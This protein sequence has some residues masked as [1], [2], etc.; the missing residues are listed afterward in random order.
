MLYE[1]IKAMNPF[2]S[3]AIEF[4]KDTDVYD[5]LSKLVDF[6]ELQIGDLKEYSIDIAKLTIMR[7]GFTE[8]VVNI[9]RKMDGTLGHY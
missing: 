8:Y 4:Y 1:K 3:I 5:E 9:V 6:S 7:V 2:A